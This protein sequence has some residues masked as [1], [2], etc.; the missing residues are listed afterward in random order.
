MLQLVFSNSRAV[1]SPEHAKAHIT[2]A[3]AAT[4]DASSARHVTHTTCLLA[5]MPC[6]SPLQ[7]WSP[8]RSDPHVIRFVRCRELDNRWCG[9]HRST[10]TTKAHVVFSPQQ[11]RRGFSWAMRR[12]TD[13]CCNLITRRQVGSPA[14]GRKTRANH[15][16]TAAPASRSSPAGFFSPC[17]G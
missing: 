7:E 16:R 10:R 4:A 1:Q 3:E 17:R 8:W 2:V 6:V 13:L 5:P 12:S 14:G 11:G 15:G 9:H